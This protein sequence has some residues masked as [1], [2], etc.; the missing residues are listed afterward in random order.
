MRT[1]AELEGPEF[2]RQCNLI[3]KEVEHFL[4]TTKVIDLGKKLPKY[5]GNETDNERIEMRN[6]QLKKNISDIFDAMLEKHP[7]ET[8]RLV[9]CMVVLDEGEEDPKGFDIL[10]IALDLITSQQ[11]MDFLSR[12]MKSGLIDIAS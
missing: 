5:K 1:L 6:A 7:E 8:Y 12:L 4:K 9:K 3:R 11:V 2:L 10:M